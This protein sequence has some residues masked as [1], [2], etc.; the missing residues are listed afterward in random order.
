MIKETH[1]PDVLNCLA[2]LSSDEVFTSPKIV[3][4]ML[5]MLPQGLFTNKNTKFLEPCC[6]SGVFL[7]EIA[8]RL[9]V[10]LENQIPNLR[11]RI[12][13][14]FTNQLYGIAIT[15]LTSL[16]TRRSLYCSKTANGK[17]SINENFKNEDGN[18]KF[19]NI[20]H[21]FKDHKCIF[22]GVSDNVETYTRDDS[23]ETHAYEFIHTYKPEELFNMKFDVIIGNPP[24]QLNDGGSGNGNSALP[25]Y[26]KFIKQA[27]KLK[28]R[29]L[30]MI[31]PSRW[32]AG[33]RGL[34]EFRS[35]MLSNNHLKYLVD[36][37]KS[38]DCFDGVDIAGGVCYFLYDSLFSGECTIINKQHN[39]EDVLVRSLNE[40]PIFI[41][42]NR[43]IGIIRKINSKI[44][45][46]FANTSFTSNP[47]GFRSF[48]RGEKTCNAD[49][50][51]LITSEGKTYID[52]INIIKN[53]QEL[54]KYKVC[55]GKINPD[56]GGVNGN[57]VNYN[58]INKPF[59]AMPNEIIS[60]SYLL[61]ETFNDKQSA[62]N[63]LQFFTTKLARFLIFMSMSSMNITN[64][65]LMFVPRLNFNKIWTDSEL[66]TF[67][68]LSETEVN[69]IEELIKPMIIEVE[70]KW[71]NL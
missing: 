27:I 2:N 21:S 7:R 59:I 46:N 42:Y 52:S 11:E 24:Y 13:H 66:Y 38:R 40:Y 48:I 1:N 45:D 58:V 43:A 30:T 5:D 32:Y 18:I 71:L 68:N 36:Y 33:G 26:D 28:P 57:A 34:D 10:G 19:D 56:R 51:A 65:N 29:Y 54:H 61:I 47:F 41:R 8:K 50:V 44:K 6:K 70:L 37:P 39:Y 31:I 16:L 35:M 55:F 12:N 15:R 22:C 20:Q 62:I 60:E 53:K 25:L 23:M 14:I 63:C 69:F 17:Y 4:E 67:F 3:N 49:S 64:N 9:L